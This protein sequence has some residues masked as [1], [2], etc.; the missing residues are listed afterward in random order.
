MAELLPSRTMAASSRPSALP[1]G[2][3]EA[4]PPAFRFDGTERSTET[5]LTETDTAA[6]LVLVDGQIRHEHYASTGG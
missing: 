2:Q 5:L 3:L 4:L 6:L 1:V